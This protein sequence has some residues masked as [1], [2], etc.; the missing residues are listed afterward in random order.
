MYSEQACAGGAVQLG[1]SK[2]LARTHRWY[3]AGSTTL[4]SRPRRAIKPG[5]PRPSASREPDQSGAASSILAVQRLLLLVLCVSVLYVLLSA[6]LPQEP[7][8]ARQQ[9]RG[10][11]GAGGPAGWGRIRRWG[12]A[13]MRRIKRRVL[14]KD[15]GEAGR[16]GARLDL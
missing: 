7:R 5:P 10:A 9:G 2:R 16:H 11:Q 13:W 4:Q 1:E 12:S 6:I 15:A 14:G 3:W 8:P